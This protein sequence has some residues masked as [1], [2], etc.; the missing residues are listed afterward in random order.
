VWLLWRLEV[1]SGLCQEAREGGRPVLKAPQKAL[2][3]R[4]ADITDTRSCFAI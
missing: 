4:D 1:E 2:R 3:Q